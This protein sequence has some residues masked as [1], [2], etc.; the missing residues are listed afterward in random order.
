MCA[1]LG[2]SYVR[3]TAAYRTGKPR[4]TDKMPNNFQHLDL[5]QLILPNARILDVRREPMACCF[6]IFK[7]LFANGHPFAYS[8]GDIGR[9][10]QLYV[11][12]MAHWERALPGKILRVQYEDLVTGLEPNVRRILEFCGLD[13]EP[14]CL[15][16]HANRRK[17]HTP[18]AAQVQQ[19]LYQ[20]AID[21]WRHFEPWLA[22]L[23]RA[24]GL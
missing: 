18:S 5:L 11:D 21:H 1:T 13:F 22:P 4:F 24:L 12:L 16:F 15:Q 17:V 3:D 19:P 9:H 14:E 20:E 10:H 23:R 7:Q 8:L 2:D 6:A